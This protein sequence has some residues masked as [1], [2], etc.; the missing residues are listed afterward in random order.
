LT[1]LA[2]GLFIFASVT[3]R[4]LVQ[5]RHYAVEI[6]DKLLHSQ[7]ALGD[8]GIYQRL[9]SLYSTILENAFGIYRKNTERIAWIHHVL[10]WIA[11]PGGWSAE[12]LHLVGIPIHVTMDVIER[13]RSVLI[14]DEA[15]KPTTE[16]QVCHASFP[17]FLVDGARC[18]DSA[19]LIEPQFGEALISRSYLELLARNDI[20]TLRDVDG[21]LPLVWKFANW[22]CIPRILRAQCTESLE[23]SLRAFAATNL[24][25]WMDGVGPWGG[26]RIGSKLEA[27][28]DAVQVREWYKT[29]GGSDKDLTALLDRAIAKRIKKFLA[30][31]SRSPDKF[32]DVD[33]ERLRRWI[34]VL[35][36]LILGGS[37]D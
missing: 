24:E 17:Q 36:P 1:D 5:D 3:V 23:T 37:E 6:Y 25:H 30:D 19:F 32:D 12:D 26:Y 16:I 2:D 7:E 15:V 35:P 29:N 20:D 8:I 34:S 27:V 18:H 31:F 4:F 13:L 14:V 33:T 9:D 10:T 21:N 22:D 11:L 28:D